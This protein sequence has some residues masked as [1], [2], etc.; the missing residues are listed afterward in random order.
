MKLLV[1]IE[2][3]FEGRFEDLGFQVQS[4]RRYWE[5]KEVVGVIRLGLW[6]LVRSMNWS[7]ES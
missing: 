7:G 3:N 2:V 5:F 1:D 4:I 6:F